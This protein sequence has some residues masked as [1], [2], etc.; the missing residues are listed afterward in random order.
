VLVNN[1]EEVLIKPL[2]KNFLQG[3]EQCIQNNLTFPFSCRR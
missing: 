3:L 2:V 1:A